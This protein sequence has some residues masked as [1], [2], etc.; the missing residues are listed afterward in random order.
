LT[1]F[2]FSLFL[3][4]L[5]DTVGEGG[6]G[7]PINLPMSSLMAFFPLVTACIFAYGREKGKGVGYLFKRVIDVSPIRRKVWYLPA[8]LLMPTAL[9]AS[10]LVMSLLNYPLPKPDLHLPM[11][12]VF[13]ALFFIGAVGEETGWMTFVV[14]P[15]QQ[16]WSALTTGIVCGLIW[17]VW[18]IVPL[19]HAGHDAAW[20]VWH[21]LVTVFLRIIIVWIYNNTGRSVLTAILFHASANVGF[22]LFPNYGSHYDPAVTGVVLAAIVGIITYFWGF[23]TLSAIR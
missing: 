14:D 15:L 18:H 2:A 9:F 13:F 11:I 17:A 10:Y 6:L 20:I 4:L 16:R 1:V 3:W 7:L 5:E 23:R 19:I 21:G 12:P 22:F 8:L